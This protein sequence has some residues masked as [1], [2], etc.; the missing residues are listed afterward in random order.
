MSYF[1]NIS[2]AIS[3]LVEGMK[4]TIGYFVRPNEHVTLQYPDEVWPVPSRN[5][6]VG[7]LDTYNTIRSKLTVNIEDCI[8]CRACERACPVDCITIDAYKGG[9]DEDLGTTSNGT[10][11]KLLTANFTIDM[12]E[13]MFCDLCTPPCPEDCIIMTPDYQ[14]ISND[15][16][17]TDITPEQR[18][19]DRGHLI[20]QF[21]KVP[22]DVRQRL[23]AEA[24]EAAQAKALAMAAKKAEAEKAAA[25]QAAREAAEV[26]SQED[27]TPAEALSPGEAAGDSRSTMPVTDIEAEKPAPDTAEDGETTRINIPMETITSQSAP[28]TPDPSAQSEKSSEESE[29]SDDSTKEENENG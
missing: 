23:K 10:K 26:S 14:F 17:R 5:I 13:C 6:G 21:S 2:N 22:E 24:E 28:T 15:N 16:L 27:S 9:P 11:I 1:N 29:Q 3:T 25:E 12:S 19:R 4:V 8:G 7:E 20:Y 18:W